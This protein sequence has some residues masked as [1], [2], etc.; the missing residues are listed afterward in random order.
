MNCRAIRIPEHGLGQASEGERP[1]QD[2][3]ITLSAADARQPTGYRYRCKEDHCGPCDPSDSHA[4]KCRTGSRPLS[5]A[6]DSAVIL[7]SSTGQAH[8]HAQLEMVPLGTTFQP[9]GPDRKSTA[10]QRTADHT[11][12]IHIQIQS[13]SP[14][15]GEAP[16]R[17]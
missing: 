11:T 8:E 13:S 15:D 16:A 17:L 5:I 1:E 3:H 4:R 9:R 6:V 10:G 7:S 14:I 12:P 2:P